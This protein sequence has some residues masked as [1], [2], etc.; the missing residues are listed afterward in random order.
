[1]K[2]VVSIFGTALISGICLVVLW[3]LILHMQDGMGH[4]GVFEI[5]G[6]SLSGL[7]TENAGAAFDACK[8]ESEKEFPR[9]TFSR[10]QSLVTGTYEI[11]TIIKAVDWTGEA[12][13]PVVKSV[14][15]PDGTRR[16]DVAGVNELTFSRRGIYT[17]E[18]LAEDEY[19]RESVK[20]IQIPVN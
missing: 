13:N 18:L 9:I 19:N 16:E 11:S 3:S 6:A 17:L 20:K 8:V 2:K 12:I 10:T 14:T 1:M 5:I 4:E 7:Q 15:E